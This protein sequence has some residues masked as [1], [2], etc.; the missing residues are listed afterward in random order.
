MLGIYKT[1]SDREYD[2]DEITNVISIREK[3]KYRYVKSPVLFTK[4]GELS[5]YVD[6]LEMR[7]NRG[8]KIEGLR[9]SK[10]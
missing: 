6:E 5:S 1:K 2:Y 4:F 8:Q 9:D 7:L 10:E 3:G